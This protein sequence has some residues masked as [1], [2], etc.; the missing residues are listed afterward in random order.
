MNSKTL[1]G[2][3]V[4][5]IS[6]AAIAD[7]SL[8][9]EN[10]QTTALHQQKAIYYFIQAMKNAKKVIAARQ[11]QQNVNKTTENNPFEDKQDFKRPQMPPEDNPQV[12][13]QKIID[14]QN[15]ILE[16][17]ETT[18]NLPQLAA[19]QEQI[20][21]AA[22]KLH[23]DLELDNSV[24]KAIEKAIKSSYES[25]GL[26]NADSKTFAKIKAEKTLSDLKEAMRIL[27]KSS[28]DKFNKT[29]E[30]A[31]KK[32][33]ELI[34]KNK[35]STLP[36]ISGELRKMR[37]ELKEKAQRQHK[38]GSQKNAEK[39]ADLASKINNKMKN[40]IQEG[41]KGKEGNKGQ[42]KQGQSN[43][44]KIGQELRQLQQNISRLQNEGKKSSQLAA[45]AIQEL[46]ALS[47][48]L[49]YL[50]KNPGS[51]SKALQSQLIQDIELRMQDLMQALE[52]LQPGKSSS[53]R[54]EKNNKYNKFNIMLYKLLKQNNNKSDGT[55]YDP[56]VYPENLRSLNLSIQE[57][58]LEAVDSLNNLNSKDLIYTYNPDDVPI[59]YRNEVAKYFERLSGPAKESKQKL[60]D[61]K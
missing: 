29:L 38:Q 7:R 56:L 33:N 41:N 48:E 14:M 5:L 8:D 44:Q 23:E 27:E 47:K 61:E 40:I 10:L 34:R 39:L 55:G 42:G 19:Q 31:R 13:L 53:S 60:K 6:L 1:A 59:K 15:K 22:S 25:S 30:S 26:M 32:V 18:K 46:K 3:Y 20:A 43:K 52:E 2:L 51:L 36:K 12:K 37:N 24:K 16:N 35:N 21:N 58:L 50:E 9:V 57:I 28:N 4:G 17:L 54:N 45:K 49:K 11:S